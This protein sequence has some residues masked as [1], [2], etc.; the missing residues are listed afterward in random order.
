MDKKLFF[1]LFGI[2]FWASAAVLMH[3]VGPLVFDG[4]WMHIGW[5]IANFFLPLPIIP[6]IA[7]AT[8]RTKH[9]MVVPTA[10]IALPAMALDG[11]SVTLDALGK[12]H[13][14]ANTP[15]LSALTG[16]FLLFAFASFFFWALIWHKA[17]D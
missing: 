8:G 2:A 6:L 1:I 4:G 16:G 13:I 7:K 3:F 12:T 15:E 10:L 14:Y 17:P 5:W 11:L 9:D